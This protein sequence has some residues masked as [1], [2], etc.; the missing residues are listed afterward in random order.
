ML[1]EHLGCECFLVNGARPAS[2]DVGRNR[3]PKTWGPRPRRSANRA[4]LGLALDP[5]ADRL[6]LVDE[7]GRP[8]GEEYTLALAGR[9]RLTREAGPLAC[10]LSTLRMMD[11]VAA[12]A[13]VPL[14]GRRSARSTWPRRSIAKDASSAAKATAA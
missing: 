10:N 2:S 11:Y 7:T 12:E 5:D 14:T 9:H 8:I 3:Y 6:A 4:A 13:G 1:L